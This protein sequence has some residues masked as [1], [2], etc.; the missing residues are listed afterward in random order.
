MRR[1]DPS[2]YADSVVGLGHSV[3][4]SSD[5]AERKDEVFERHLA[6][7]EKAG[8]H[9]WIAIQSH[10]ISDKVAEQVAKGT[11]ENV[12]MDYESLLNLGFGCYRCE[13]PLT[14]QTFY[15]RCPGDPG[16]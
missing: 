1:P 9:L 12:I 6:T 3:H 15:R 4:V 13:Q 11:A 8:T 14:K 5:Q 2:N 7:A 16:E 10:S